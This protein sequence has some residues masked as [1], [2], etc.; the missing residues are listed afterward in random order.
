MGVRVG[1]RWLQC[2]VVTLGLVVG[3][4]LLGAASGHAQTIAEILAKKTLVIGVLVDFPP[5]G[6]M[7]DQQKA[8]GFDIDLANLM[9]KYM[10]VNAVIVPVSN[11]N[12]IPFLQTKKIDVLV[13]SL[14]ITPE[15]SKQVMFTDPYVDV[16]VAIAAPKKVPLTDVEQLTQYSVA[17][18]RGSSQETYIDALAPKGAK[19]MRFDGEM[20]PA[21]AMVSGQ[22]DA[23]A[24]STIMIAGI[25]K[26]NPGLQIE[27]KIVLKHQANAIAVRLDAFE[28][29]HWINTFLYRSNS[30]GSWISCTA[31]GWERRCPNCRCSDHQAAS[32][33]RPSHA[34]R[35]AGRAT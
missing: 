23:W 2:A 19:I 9:A 4:S 3:G 10:G 30:A 6:F 21:Q 16:N 20:P 24:D 7:N 22:A 31:S 5:F 13:A 28:F 33:V 18:A 14:G 35:V 15:R 11:P 8:D 26:A 17:V 27:P 34:Q 25:A 32:C 1:L 12:R 29:E